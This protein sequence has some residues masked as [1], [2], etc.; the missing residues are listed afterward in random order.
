MKGGQAATLYGSAGVNGALVITTKKGTKGKAKV[1]FSNSTNIEQLS[2][3]PDFQDKYGNGSHYAT[4]AGPPG[5]KPDYLE[6]MK[7]NWRPFEN[8]QYGDAYDGQPRIIGRQLE[9]GS[10]NIVPYSAID[11]ERKKIWN[12]GITT[13]NQIA[14]DGGAE[15]PVF[16]LSVENNP[17]QGIVPRDKSNRTGVRFSAGTEPE[18]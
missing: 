6:R 5:W 11:G 1:T 16:R 18:G 10:Q 14:V 13:N 12:T 2:F 9:D 17:A 7:D 15:N 4:P 8:Q 3:L